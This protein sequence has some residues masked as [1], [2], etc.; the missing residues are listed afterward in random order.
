MK[1]VGDVNCNFFDVSF[2]IVNENEYCGNIDLLI[3]LYCK[4]FWSKLF[5]LV[6]FG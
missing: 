6:F 2:K 5:V 4:F 1:F 3:E